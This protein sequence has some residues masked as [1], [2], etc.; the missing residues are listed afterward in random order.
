MNCCHPQSAHVLRAF[1]LCVFFLLLSLQKP[2]PAPPA[3]RVLRARPRP[4]QK[5]AGILSPVRPRPF[6]RTNVS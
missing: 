4:L 2:L 1:L 3:A 6:F 5:V